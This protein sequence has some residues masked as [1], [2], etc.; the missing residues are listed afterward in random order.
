MNTNQH[1]RNRH[2]NSSTE[3]GR[4]RWSREAREMDDDRR[5]SRQMPSGHQDDRGEAMQRAWGEESRSGRDDQRFFAGRRMGADDPQMDDDPGFGREREPGDA[6][7]WD[8]VR[9]MDEGGSH[10]QRS[11]RPSRGR[12]YIQPQHS[13]YGEHTGG[14]GGGEYGGSQWEQGGR[15]PQ[16][17][18]GLMQR[19]PGGGY[20]GGQY[21]DEHGGQRFGSGQR[22]GGQYG[23]SGSGSWGDRGSSGDYGSR[24][25]SQGSY[26]QYGGQQYGQSQYGQGQFG[27]QYGQG[28]FGDPRGPGQQGHQGSHWTQR[29]QRQ[30]ELIGKGPKGF[31]RSDERIQEEVNERL[32]HGFLDASEIEVK[33][34]NG[35]VTLTG[36]VA[37]KES[38][39]L[40]EDLL[41]DVGGAKDIDNRVKVKARSGQS[42]S[43]S[44]S[45][46]MSSEGNGGSSS[47]NGSGSTTGTDDDKGRGSSKRAHA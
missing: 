15:T 32:A 11:G 14:S 7:E 39:R 36:T 3:D 37:S 17:G 35:N 18:A 45:Q 5:T 47:S 22:Q 19:G 21:G 25:Q 44:P 27:S 43:S 12:Q 31:T 30:P 13:Q 2:F 9:R 34:Q 10:G 4:D 42:T 23:S 26:G 41:E 6:S 20:G 24:Q 46:A 33:V 28:Q 1:D 16:Y 38:K 40:V 8:D 29:G